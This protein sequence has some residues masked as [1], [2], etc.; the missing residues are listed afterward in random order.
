MAWRW[1]TLSA[2]FVLMVVWQWR[3]NGGQA[4]RVD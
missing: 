1:V 4:D 2:G 3:H